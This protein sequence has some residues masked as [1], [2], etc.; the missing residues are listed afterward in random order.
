MKPWPTSIAERYPIDDEI[1][2]KV[3][4]KFAERPW[5]TVSEF[6]NTLERRDRV[7]V[8]WCPSWSEPPKGGFAFAHMADESEAVRY[9]NVETWEEFLALAGKI[10]KERP[11]PHPGFRVGQ[12]WAAVYPGTGPGPE[13]IRAILGKYARTDTTD[14]V[15]AVA[16]VALASNDEPRCIDGTD[17]PLHVDIFRS[18]SYPYL[19]HDAVCPWTAPW[20]PPEV[21]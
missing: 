8:E 7:R 4:H 18:G 6:T 3:L 9:E 12:V 14:G 15:H 20:S 19:V 5:W 16:I 21:S 11:L 17:R 2:R 10:D 13:S 1:N